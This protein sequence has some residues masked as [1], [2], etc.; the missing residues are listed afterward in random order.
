MTRVAFH[1]RRVAVALALAAI[2]AAAGCSSLGFGSDWRNSDCRNCEEDGPDRWSEEWYAMRDGP[3]G[4]R[5]ARALGKTWPPGGRRPVGEPRQFSHT[6]HH[7]HYWP[8]PYTQQ[9][10]DYVSS[11]SE[12]HTNKGWMRATTLYKYHFDPETHELTHPGRLHLRWI[13]ANAPE[14]HRLAFVQTAPGSDVSQARMES[15]REVAVEMVG[16]NNLPPI[17]L[18][19]APTIDR[20]AYEIDQL[21][22]LRA[23]SLRMPRIPYNGSGMNSGSSMSGNSGSGG[24]TLSGSGASSGGGGSTGN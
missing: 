22:R 14:K 18:R 20:P 23:N 21:E 15:V 5:Q 4:T 11:L 1:A 16:E 13:L 17:M 8:Y 19:V 24:G 12:Q 2:V 7:A 6:F 10:K 3:P 9:D